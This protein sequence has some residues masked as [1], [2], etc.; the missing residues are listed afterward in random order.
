MT[1]REDT[2]RKIRPQGA[3][4]AIRSL[5]VHVEPGAAAQPRL[6]AAVALAEKLDAHLTGLGA[7]MSQAAGVSDPFGLLGS[8]WTVELAALLQDNLKRAETAFRAKSAGLD[9][10]WLAVQAYPAAAMARLARGADLVIAGGAPVTFTDDDR[11]AQTAELVLQCGRP[12]LV[13]PPTGGRLRGEAVVVAWK[14]TREARR[15]VADALPFLQ[16]AEEVVVQEVCGKESHDAAQA[17]TAAVVQNLKRHGVLARAKVT[18]G[19]AD[20]AA[21]ELEATAHGLG[22]DLIVA[23]GYGHTRLGEWVFGGVTRNLLQQPDHFVLFSH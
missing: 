1:L 20:D 17:H 7:E 21:D 11:V 18:V 14:D 3:L 12:V 13:V 23:G 9:V 15:A 6:A 4:S 5:L 2:A 8:D 10:E 16:A 22:A 19:A